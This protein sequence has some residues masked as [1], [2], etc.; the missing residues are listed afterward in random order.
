MSSPQEK[1]SKEQLIDEGSR[2]L[3]HLGRAGLIGTSIPNPKRPGEFISVEEF[4]LIYDKGR[5][6][7]HVRPYLAV[8]ENMPPDDPD[9]DDLV[10]ILNEMLD[11][12]LG[13]GQE[14]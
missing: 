4:P 11:K 9:H 2:L 5:Y 1:I 13:I 6:E 8:L 12:H 14:G 10:K 3:K 7:A